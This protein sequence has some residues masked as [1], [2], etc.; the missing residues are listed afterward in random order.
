MEERRRFR[1]VDG[2]VPRRRRGAP[3]PAPPRSFLAERGEFDGAS[4]RLELRPAESPTP[5]PSP[6]VPRG[7]GRIRSRFDKVRCTSLPRAVCGGGS[8]RGAAQHPAPNAPNRLQPCP[9]PTSPS[10]FWGRCE[11]K[12]AE[13]AREASR[14]APVPPLRVFLRQQRLDLLRGQALELVD[15]GGEDGGIGA[16]D[17]GGQAGDGGVLKEHAD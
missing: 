4:E 17:G 7:E 8:G 2:L 15:H 13:G 14:S 3:P 11:P 12:R 9:T 6:L 10:L 16:L 5:G 1:C